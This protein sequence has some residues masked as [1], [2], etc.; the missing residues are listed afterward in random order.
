M[1]EAALYHSYL[2]R[3]M[4]ERQ[5]LCQPDNVLAAELIIANS[6]MHV[7]IKGCFS[8]MTLCIEWARE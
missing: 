6:W 2:Y 4:T 7:W 8:Y 5:K 1:A 3:A